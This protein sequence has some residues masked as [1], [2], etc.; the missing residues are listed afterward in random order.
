MNQV[1]GIYNLGCDFVGF[2]KPD[3]IAQS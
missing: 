3:F 2:H 1:G